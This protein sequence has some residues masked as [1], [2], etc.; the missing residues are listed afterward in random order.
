M[1]LD[2]FPGSR[3]LECAGHGLGST[4]NGH[5]AKGCMR[6]RNYGLKLSLRSAGLFE[7][8][9]CEV[10]RWVLALEMLLV[11]HMGFLSLFPISYL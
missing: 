6:A 9:F 11:L 3:D 4:L 7:Y 5:T 8:G 2:T 1:L 10:L